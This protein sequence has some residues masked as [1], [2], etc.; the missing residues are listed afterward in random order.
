MEITEITN[1]ERNFLF[2]PIYTYKVTEEDI[3]ELI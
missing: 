2:S 3:N 1:E